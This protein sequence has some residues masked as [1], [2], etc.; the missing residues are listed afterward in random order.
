M[1]KLVWCIIIFEFHINNDY[2]NNY[3]TE[4]ALILITVQETTTNN[5]IVFLRVNYER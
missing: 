2:N 5:S 3:S 4:H 1:L